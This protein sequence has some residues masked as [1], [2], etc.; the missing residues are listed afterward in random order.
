MSGTRH[1]L[2]TVV[3]GSVMSLLAILFL[4]GLS[5]PEWILSFILA[6]PLPSLC[7]GGA[8]ALAYRR[9]MGGIANFFI[10]LGLGGVLSFI[11]LLL[12]GIWIPTVFGPLAG[13][14]TAPTALL[15]AIAVAVE[16]MRHRQRM[17]DGVTTDG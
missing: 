12:Y 15:S 10:A 14:V 6:G 17:R 8:Q 4:G 11:F 5:E 9:T 1:L 7:I 16:A 2:T 13:V 3:I